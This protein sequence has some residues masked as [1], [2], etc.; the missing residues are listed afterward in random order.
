MEFKSVEE[1]FGHLLKVMSSQRFLH[2]E[3]LGNEVPFFVSPYPP[4]QETHMEESIE[5]LLIKP[6]RTRFGVT[7]IH[8]NL[9]D[10]CVEI[11]KDSGN[12]EAILDAEPQLE[13]DEKLETMR[14]C[15]SP[16]RY[17]IPKIMEK[18]EGRDYDVLLLSGAGTVYPFLRMHTIFENLQSSIKDKPTVLLFPGRYNYSEVNG[19]V[20]NLFGE[21]DDDRYYRAFN[22]DDYLV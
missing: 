7:V 18:L 20:L 2:R 3:G 6:L 11:L 1:R 15:V 21:F 9:Y 4:S 10:L 5:D 8:L 16:K 14:N 22:L 13:R 17:L 19:R 12:W